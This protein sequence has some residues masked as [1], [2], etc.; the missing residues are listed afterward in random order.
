MT[1]RRGVLPVSV[2]CVFRFG[3]ECAQ[4]NAILCKLLIKNEI[5]LSCR[6]KSQP[7]NC[8]KTHTHTHAL[9]DTIPV[10][11][12][13]QTKRTIGKAN[14]QTKVSITFSTPRQTRVAIMKFHFLACLGSYY[15]CCCMLLL[16]LLL[17][18]RQLDILLLMCA[19][20][21]WSSPGPARVS[22]RAVQSVR[23]LSTSIKSA[24][25]NDI[26]L[27]RCRV[28]SQITDHRSLIT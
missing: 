9:C 4:I 18:R 25:D 24:F 12:E 2:A 27:A 1:C 15:C 11:A 13:L 6:H 5:N 8:N 22:S 17:K 26:C 7:I 19:C 3:R 14:L 21:M 23:A 10:S 16:L 20:Q 28:A